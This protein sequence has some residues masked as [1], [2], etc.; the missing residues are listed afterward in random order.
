MSSRGNGE[1][2]PAHDRPT[3][4]RAVRRGAVGDASW[5]SP[6][7]SVVVPVALVGGVPVTVV[8]VVDVIAVQNALVPA[9][10]AVPVVVPLVRHMPARLA[11]VPVPLVL[12]VH[13]TVVRVVDVV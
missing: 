13:M 9:V 4:P 2:D 3:V 8:E 5:W 7:R 10:L 11:L 1:R 12:A 6:L